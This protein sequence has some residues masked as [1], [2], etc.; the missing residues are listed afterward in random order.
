[1][2]Y[3]SLSCL[4]CSI[5]YEVSSRSE[6]YLHAFPCMFYLKIKLCI[7]TLILHVCLMLSMKHK[8][9]KC[10]VAFLKLLQMHAEMLSNIGFVL[11]ALEFSVV[12]RTKFRLSIP[13]EDIPRTSYVY[14]SSEG[15]LTAF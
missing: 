5:L 14:G 6:L 11:K 8:Q 10:I 7:K 15:V 4:L 13:S 1:M 2:K 12:V 9:C 3:F